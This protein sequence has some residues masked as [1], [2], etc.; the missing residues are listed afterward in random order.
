MSVTQA[1]DF[2][3]QWHLTGRCN[4]R[5]RHCYQDNRQQEE[6]S[7]SEIARVIEAAARM[8]RDWQEDYDIEFLPSFNV[9]G[10]EPF[11]RPDFFPL[12]ELL[13]A[14]G[15]EVYV[16]SNGTLISEE[17]AARLAALGV[18]GVQV[19]LEGTEETHDRIR[20]AGSF[21]AAVAGIRHLLA[22]GVKVS[23]NT[24]LSRMNVANFREL[25]ELAVALG[26]PRLGFSRLVLSGRGAALQEQ[27]LTTHEVQAFYEE[28]LA[29]KVQGLEITSGDP[30]AFQMESPPPVED[31]GEIAL[32]GC[33][34]GVSGLTILPDGT[35]TPCRRLPIPIGNVRRDSL[36]ELWAASPV[37]E[38]LRDRGQY[39]G[40]C[41]ECP[42][43]AQC[44][45]CRAIAYA[46]S[47]S[48]GNPDY[49]S[50]D[51]QCFIDLN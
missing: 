36:R 28:I 35:V 18:H 24:T 48:R 23:L 42:R 10:G 47:R 19:S 34:A 38:G 33:A 37:L 50:S 44:R 7:F 13:L 16:L 26:V 41:G 20:G 12:L 2:L 49:L 39:H 8:V 32:G 1:F 22:A 15:F 45:G 14:T 21:A 30:I 5:C 27:M 46:Y 6:M 17:R 4:L 3:I 40:R 51:P 11:L 31:E 25:V 43:W 9:T 29:L